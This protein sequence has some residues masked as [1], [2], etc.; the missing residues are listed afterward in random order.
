MPSD[1]LY[2]IK[3]VN[4]QTSNH[5]YLE[6]TVSLREKLEGGFIILA[7]RLKKIRDTRIYDPEYESFGDFL[8]EIRISESSAS[9]LIGVYEKFVLMG[10]IPA[11]EVAKVGWTNISLFLP[12][13]KTK[14][15]AIEIWDKTHLLDRTDAQRV[16]QEMKTGVDMA[17]CAHAEIRTLIVC[18]KCGIKMEKTHAE[19]ET[20]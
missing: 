5:Q 8:R 19:E 10:G 4:L 7:E 16:Y 12:R 14:D 18:T 6:E 1:I 3:M 9:K 13:I 11:D 17:E 15:D 20:D 2:P